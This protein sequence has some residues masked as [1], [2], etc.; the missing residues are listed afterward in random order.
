LWLH[1]DGQ[2]EASSRTLLAQ[3]QLPQLPE[4]GVREAGNS[5][6]E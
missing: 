4:V 3:M 6:I 2:A 5:G 1:Q